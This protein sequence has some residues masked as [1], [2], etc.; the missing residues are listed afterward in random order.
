VNAADWGSV[1]RDVPVAVV[2]A[3]GFIGRWV[4]RFLSSCGAVLHLAVRDADAAAPLFR[5][6]G[7]S[8]EVCEVDLLDDRQISCFLQNARP[9]VT[10]NL[11]G[12]GVDRSELDPHLARRLNT[13]LP[14]V[15]ATAIAPQHP[16]WS[17][18]G[19]V[20]V[21]SGIEYGRSA[22]EL[23][24]TSI[25]TPPDTLYA[26][27]KLAGTIALQRFSMENGFSALTARLFTVYGPG[28]HPGRLLPSL[29]EAAAHGGDLR[30]SSGYQQRDFVYV[31]DV[32]EGLLRLGAA[33]RRPA[34]T[35]I[36]L[37]T[38]R[39]TT[40]R[41]FAETAADILGIPPAKLKFGALPVRFDEMN[42]S[43]VSLERLCA[44]TGWTPQTSLA[45]G[46]RATFRFSAA[47]RQEPVLRNAPELVT[48]L[49]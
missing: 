27:T 22:C 15:L 45:E 34:H 16:T 28:E 43:S 31:G 13:D 25:P 18:S 35:T 11:A 19:L 4:A 39:M 46:I 1:Y 47:A 21:G 14:A 30:L 42:Y 9:A 8:G 33:P 32:A 44:T 23:R 37:A 48:P 5:E 38:G 17:G 7:V 26:Q 2:G 29:L 20:H 3:A 6:Y 10:F 41:R 36:N 12:Y 24:E 40:V 49:N